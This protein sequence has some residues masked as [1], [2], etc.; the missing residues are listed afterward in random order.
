MNEVSKVGCKGETM[1]IA[2]RRPLWMVL[3]AA[4]LHSAAL[5]GADDP[6]LR[7][8]EFAE[9][10][11]GSDFRIVLYS[12]DETT[13]NRASRA[14]F[15]RVAELNRVLSDY[16][17]Q[18]ELSRLS[19]TSGSG[20]QVK[21]SDDLWLVLDRAQQLAAATDGAFDV[22]VGPLTKMWRSARRTKQF[23]TDDR[24]AEARAAVGYKH[25][26]LDAATQTAELVVPHMRLDLGGIAMGHAADEALRIVARHGI[27]S[28][29]IDASGDIVCSAAPPGE[30]GWKIGLAPLTENQE[31][32]SRYVWL[33]DQAL[34]T[35]GDAFQFV[36]IGGRRF[37]HI[38]DPKT[39][40][41]LTERSSVT[42][43][44]NDCLT[45]DS[46][47]TAVSVLGPDRGLKLIKETKGAVVVIVRIGAAGP[48]T[49]ASPG[50]PHG[51][52]KS[53]R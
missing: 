18:S 14:A 19:A 37:S 6:V 30:R 15:D 41:G 1:T 50:F 12:A 25:L 20:R 5:Q 53:S 49:T 33:A 47:A 34:T 24:M 51:N 10:H 29:M 27:R 52:E 13:A 3:F 35:S 44:A 32:P 42:V 7:R 31:T 39:G 8:Y 40:L 4:T 16:D 46:L 9:V 43:I 28:A 48:M 26:R 17:P 21:I 38:V 22:T 2:G 45:A 11:M 23:P 36:E